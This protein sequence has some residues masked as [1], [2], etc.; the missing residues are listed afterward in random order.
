MHFCELTQSNV[1]LENTS[2]FIFLIGIFVGRPNNRKLTFP[3]TKWA[4]P[5]RT[6]PELTI[7]FPSRDM[8]SLSAA[9]KASSSSKLFL[10]VCKCVKIIWKLI[11]PQNPCIFPAASARECQH[12]GVEDVGLRMH[13]RVCTHARW[14]RPA[15]WRFTGCCGPPALHNPPTRQPEKELPAVLEADSS[16][17]SIPGARAVPSSQLCL[18]LLQLPTASSHTQLGGCR[19]LHHLSLGMTDSPYSCALL[20]CDY[21]L[22]MA[23]IWIRWMPLTSLTGICSPSQ[24]VSLLPLTRTPCTPALTPSHVSAQAQQVQRHGASGA[25]KGYKHDLDACLEE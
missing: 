7:S 20:L 21:L 9:P 6:Y 13:P 8:L 16:S 22:F 10:Y 2:L 25:W 4:N 17:C 1:Y 19:T 5:R 3:N 11:A 14:G 18:A 24:H 12:T 15:A 23:G